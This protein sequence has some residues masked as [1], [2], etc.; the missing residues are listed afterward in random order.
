M[1]QHR[2]CMVPKKRILAKKNIK[3]I[4]KWWAAA[5]KSNWKI[6][7]LKVSQ[8]SVSLLCAHLCIFCIYCK[9]TLS[10]FFACNAPGADW[11]G[12]N[13]QK[14]EIKGNLNQNGL[15]DQLPFSF[16]LCLQKGKDDF[17]W[18]LIGNKAILVQDKMLCVVFPLVRALAQGAEIC[19]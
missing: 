14:M 15:M 6:G 19:L 18:Q 10:A 1:Y 4:F 3:Q 17:G 2:T 16:S 11:D 7:K 9:Y 5:A 13:F 12:G 8:V